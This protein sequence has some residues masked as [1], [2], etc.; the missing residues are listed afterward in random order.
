MNRT[1]LHIYHPIYKQK[2][3]C[4]IRKSMT[5]YLPSSFLKSFTPDRQVSWFAACISAVIIF[6]IA[7]TNTFKVAQ[8]TKAHCTQHTDSALFHNCFM[9][10]TK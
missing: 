9:L 5:D 7:C 6:H 10:Y 1:L 2:L 4:F 8:T 3:Q